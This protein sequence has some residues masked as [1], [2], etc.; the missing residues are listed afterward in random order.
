MLST[1]AVWSGQ[2]AIELLVL[3][4]HPI[5]SG[6]KINR[7]P[8]N[9]IPHCSSSEFDLTDVE[10]ACCF[11]QGLGLLVTELDRDAHRRSP[12]GELM[13]SKLVAPF[14][15]GLQWNGRFR[16]EGLLQASPV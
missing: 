6:L 7:L 9:Q 16:G 2:P 4:E 5:R 13:A 8:S 1:L 15:D 12:P 11:V 14:A 10:T 3:V